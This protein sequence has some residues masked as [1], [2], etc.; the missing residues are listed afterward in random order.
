MRVAFSSWDGRIAPVFDVAQR[1]HLVDL[2]G[3]RPN[4]GRDATLDGASPAL[5]ARDLAQLEVETLVCG[6]ISRP[7]LAAVA[8]RGI[9]VVPFVAGEVDRVV[10]AFVDGS[11]ERGAF[12]MPG[13]RGGGRGRGGRRGAPAA[14]ACTHCGTRVAHEAGR[15]CATV[16]CPRCG[17]P[18]RRG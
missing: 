9:R 13:C 1:V 12:A 15:P 11:L 3:G 5:R 17:R 10:E 6:A 2:V 18:M 7:V 4:G 16:R 14:C 8:A